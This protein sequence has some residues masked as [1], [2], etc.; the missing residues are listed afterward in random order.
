MAKLRYVGRGA[1]LP[2]VPSRD[3]TA[4][5]MKK[6]GG[7]EFL[8]GRNPPLYER[9]H[10]KR[11]P[12]R[13]RKPKSKEDIREPQ[14]NETLETQRGEGSPPAVAPLQGGGGGTSD[15]LRI[16]YGSRE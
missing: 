6:Y 16:R 12:K 1:F 8:L 13:R 11:K 7:E 15:P 14:S 3:L 9:V 5:E 2:G 10:P 4:A